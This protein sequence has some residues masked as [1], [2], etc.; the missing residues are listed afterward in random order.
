MVKKL[1]NRILIKV[2]YRSKLNLWL[3]RVFYNN[4][5][6]FIANRIGAYV[7]SR[8]AKI[9]QKNGFATKSTNSGDTL[10]EKGFLIEHGSV[11]VDA[12]TNVAKAWSDYADAQKFP[13]NGRLE[14]SSADQ[15]TDSTFFVPLLDKL[16]TKNIEETL[17]SFFQSHFRI[18][19]FHLYR[20]RTPSGFGV[21]DAYGATANWHTDG[22]TSESLK[23]FFMV[24]NVTSH[25]G[26][27]EVI[28]KKETKMVYLGER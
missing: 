25:N 26:P 21:T 10:R 18:I 23:L 2:L 15:S 6:G 28:S 7:W 12:I 9:A 17:E 22:S 19:N 16:I 14:L 1:L 27:M 4:Y 13:Q 8:D 5:N 3:G 24:S 20:N 11:D